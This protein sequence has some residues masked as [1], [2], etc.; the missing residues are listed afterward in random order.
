MASAERV[1]LV[2]WSF[3]NELQGMIEKYYAPNHPEIEFEFQIYP[4]DG[5]AYTT[6]LDNM[7]SNPDSAKSPNAPDIFTVEAAFVKKYTNSGATGNLKDVGFADAEL[8]S[9]FPVMA[10]IGQDKSGTQKGLSWQSTPGVLMYRASLAEKYLGVK[11]PEEMQEKVKN[12][13]AFLETAEELKVKSEGACKIVTGTSDLWNVY[14]YAR[15]YGWVVDGKLNIDDELMDYEELC[16]TLEQDDLTQKASTWG[17]TWFAGMRGELETLCYFLPTWGLNYTLKPNCV[18]GWDAENPDS[19]ENIKNATENGTYGDWRVTDGPVAYSWGGTWI[20]TNAAKVNAADS[21]KKKAI[22]DLINFFTLDT[23]FLTQYAADTG[24]FVGNAK[25]VETILTNGVAPN[26]FLGGQDHYTVFARA[27]ALANGKLLTEYDNEINDLWEKFVTVPY[28]KGEQDIDACIEE[29]KNQVTTVINIQFSDE[30]NIKNSLII[31]FVERAYQL[32]LGREAETDGLNFWSEKLRSGTM[33]AAEVINGF[34]NSVEF[35]NKNLD[36]A[37]SVEVLYRVMLNRG[38]DAA[39]KAYWVS[40]L[41]GGN[42]LAAIISG[43]CQSDEFRAIC[44]EYGITP[45]SLDV[46]ELK[47]AKPMPIVD[48]AKIRAFVTRCYQII[49]SRQPEEDGL[50]FWTKLLA[51][52]E[53]TAAEVV[54]G[55]VNSEEFQK[56]N[57]SY[58]DSVEVMYKVMLNRGSDAAGKAYWVSILNGGNPLAAIISGFCESDE[59]TG[60]CAQYGITPG[61]LEVGELKPAK[62][63]PVVDMDKIKAFATRCYRI[64]LSREPETDGLNFWANKLASGEMT[65]AEVVNGFANSDEFMDKQL[66]DSEAVE[67][68]YKVML[69]RSSDAQGKAYWLSV[70][71]EG[72]PFAAIINGFCESNEFKGICAEYGIT[73]G[74]VAVAAANTQIEPEEETPVTADKVPETIPTAE[75]IEQARAFVIHCYQSALGREGSADEVDFHAEKIANGQ[76]T[77][78][79]VAGAFISSPEFQGKNLDNTAYI[80]FLYRLCLGREAD[81][82]GLTYWTE[83]MANGET[84]QSVFNGFTES[85]EFIRFCD[86]YGIPSGATG[87]RTVEIQVSTTGEESIA[88][89]ETTAAPASEFANEEKVR[90]FVIRFYRNALGREPDVEG[91]EHF[92]SRILSGQATP[93]DTAR[94]ILCSD[95]FRNRMPDNGELVKILYRVY[96]GRE[97]DEEGYAGWVKQLDDHVSLE[98]VMNSFATSEEFM[99]VLNAMK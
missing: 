53:M 68:L 88:T 46:G 38:S 97:A 30:Q 21:E 7:L 64:I 91:L 42:P 61:S 71:A 56:K 13:N 62:P 14:Q 5:N 84:P 57:L 48:T 76:M 23:A 72:E 83:S 65:A 15:K 44:T 40:I 45:G 35:Q 50:A 74:S 9:A 70:L 31:S 3:T 49:L 55:F 80:R 11:S 43:F 33:T 78:K 32:I 18:A 63:V 34:V 82:E 99:R 51:N 37:D 28:T 10:E 86:G 39:G 77:A 96:L 52:G 17:E 16:K 81:A 1:K 59:F 19:E 92:V 93:K 20:E 85:D 47:P 12:W 41:N 29:F 79:Q 6:K 69:D 26:P 36:Y 8:A 95:E 87:N 75:N 22:K 89:E 2:I 25:A 58:G 90:E 4:T 94:E 27:A 98:N 60:I 24:D 67:V 54:N 73:P 66:D